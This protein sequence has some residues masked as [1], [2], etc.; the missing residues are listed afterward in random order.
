MHL[1][2]KPVFL[3]NK[4]MKDEFGKEEV[5]KFLAFIVYKIIMNRGMYY[6]DREKAA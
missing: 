3:V 4:T 2:K 5:E 6:A 1:K